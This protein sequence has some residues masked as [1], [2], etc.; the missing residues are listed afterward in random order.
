MQSDYNETKHTPPFY[1]TFNF[2]EALRPTKFPMQSS[3][4]NEN[5]ELQSQVCNK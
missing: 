5:I 2:P 1:V 4:S 3:I